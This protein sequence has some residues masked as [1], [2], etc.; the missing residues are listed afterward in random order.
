VF[1]QPPGADLVAPGER[2]WPRRDEAYAAIALL[3]LGALYAAI[4]L[5]PWAF[6][7]ANALLGTPDAVL[8]HALLVAGGAGLVAPLLWAGVAVVARAAARQPGASL[9]RVW[10]ATAYAL[11]PLGLT[12]WIAFTVTSIA[13]SLGYIPPALADP[14][15]WGWEPDGNL[16]SAGAGQVAGALLSR[17]AAIGSAAQARDWA[18][19]LLLLAGTAWSTRTARQAAGQV[20]DTTGARRRATAALTVALTVMATGILLLL[21][22]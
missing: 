8:R 16:V 12:T 1:L 15:G 14:L 19:V 18:L 9:R 11:V 5:G 20:F 17:L 13:G 22:A 10:A 3:A 21:L 4:Y 6:L 7:R 2:G